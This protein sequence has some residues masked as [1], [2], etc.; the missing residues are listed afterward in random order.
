MLRVGL[1][2]SGAGTNLPALLDACAYP[3]FPA[4]I[5]LVGC[6]RPDAP[7]IARAEA[8]GVPVCLTDRAVIPRRADRQQR[9]LEALQAME[10]RLVVLPAFDE[11]IIPPFLA[12]YS[13]SI[14][15]THPSLF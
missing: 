15:N 13:R 6:N 1:L 10:V 8:A 11:I 12:P 4:R 5:V 2:V 14:L 7:A 9:L 3:G